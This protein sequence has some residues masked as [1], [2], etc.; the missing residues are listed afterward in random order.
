MKLVHCVLLA[1][2]SFPLAATAS[3][4]ERVDGEASRTPAQ[5]TVQWRGA[6]RAAMALPS[7]RYGELSAERIA[8]LHAANRT[9]AHKATQIGIAR[10]AAH[11]GAGRQLPALSW[12]P[13]AAGGHV[14]RFEVT[15]P[16]ALGLRVGLRIEGLPDSAE[17]RF[18]GSE[19]PLGDLLL[20]RG[21]EIANA[22]LEDG[23]FWSPVTD[24]ET[25]AIEIFLPAGSDPSRVR[26]AAPQLSHLLANSRR[27]FKIVEKI[28]ESGSCNVD[29]ACRVGEL[30]A[31]FVHA[32]N[33]VAHMVYNLFNTNGSL[34]GTYICTGTL[35]NDTVPTTQVPYFYT[36]DHCFAGGSGGVPAQ[37]R[38]NVANTLTTHWN[39]EAT[40][41]GSG[42]STTRTQVTGGADVLFN[43]ANSDA[44]LLRLRNAAPTDATFSGWDSAP[45]GSGQ[46]VFAIHH[47]SGDAKKVSSGQKTGQDAVSHRVGWISGTTEGGSSGSGLFTSG[48]GGFLLRGGLYG[49]NASCANTGSVSNANNFD[50]YSRLDVVFPQIRQHLAPQP[51]RSNGA[52]PLVP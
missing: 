18:G 28:G 13:L 23:V 7:L 39:Y 25:Q 37:N 21:D 26:V 44:M 42:V 17:L 1:V 29:T 46:A 5:A 22:T 34:Y 3:A 27:N 24:G 31:G 10:T 14:A 38:Q 2:L 6:K 49:G 50:W 9:R 4:V 12:E 36:A 8:T 16:V 51:M 52:Q 48:P 33:A 30:G 11:E 20:M 32:K 45:L 47:P 41:C 15:S 40:S 43:D 19:L 35:L